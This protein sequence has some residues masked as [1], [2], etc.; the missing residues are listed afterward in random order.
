[1]QHL[2]PLSGLARK[3]KQNL[4]SESKRMDNVQKLELA[5]CVQQ[6]EQAGAG[7]CAREVKPGSRPKYWRTLD[8][9]AQTPEFEEMLHREFPSTPRNGRTTVH[10]ATS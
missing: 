10:A 5:M 9:L 2:P 6:K 1:L 8:E 7:R 3:P 4:T